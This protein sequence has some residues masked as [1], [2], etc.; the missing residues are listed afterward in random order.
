MLCIGIRGDWLKEHRHIVNTPWVLLANQIIHTQIRTPSNTVAY[1]D[2][3]TV[4]FVCVLNLI[5]KWC[6]DIIFSKFRFIP[7]CVHPQTC[8]QMVCSGVCCR[9]CVKHLCCRVRHL[10]LLISVQTQPQVQTYLSPQGLTEWKRVAVILHIKK[11]CFSGR[12]IKWH[13][14]VH[15]YNFW[16][17]CIN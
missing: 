6:T 11:K 7:K 14:T 5:W 15:E 12:K 9:V 17:I 13:M 8:S 1:T 3:Y 4:S 10:S 2:T 16:W